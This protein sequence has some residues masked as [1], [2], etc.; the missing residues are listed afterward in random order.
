MIIIGI[1]S[2]IRRSL[3]ILNIIFIVLSKYEKFYKI[4]DYYGTRVYKTHSIYAFC[5]HIGKPTRLSWK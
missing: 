2:D 1:L 4:I 5:V 3:F